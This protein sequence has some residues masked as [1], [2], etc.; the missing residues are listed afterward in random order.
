MPLASKDLDRP[1]SVRLAT[2]VITGFLVAFGGAATYVIKDTRELDGRLKAAETQLNDVAEK[3][4]E[5]SE[6]TKKT[7]EE[8]IPK[9]DKQLALLQQRLP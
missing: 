2:Y 6:D 4:K 5:I 1:L 8:D 3:V 7:R 9:L